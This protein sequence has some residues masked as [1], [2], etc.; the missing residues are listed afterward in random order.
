MK[1]AF[2]GF[3]QSGK[4]TLFN[5]IAGFAGSAA[6]AQR[7]R[8]AVIRIPDPRLDVL[9]HLYQA[10]KL[11]PSTATFIDIEGIVPGRKGNAS[12]LSRIRET[13]CLLGV[14]R[15]EDPVQTLKNLRIELAFA[16][17]EIIEKSMERLERAGRNHSPEQADHQANLALLERLKPFFEE[18]G[19]G[20]PPGLADEEEKRLRGYQFLA[21]KPFLAL[22]NV[23][24]GKEAP[25]C[26]EKT[27]DLHLHVKLEAELME[28]DEDVRIAFM[29]DLGL[30][31]S[32][33]EN[34]LRKSH[35]KLHLTTFF[36]AAPNE[37]RAWEI[38]PGASTVDAAGRIHTDLARGF[39]R[40][41]VF[42]YDDLVR[43]GSERGVKA[44]GKF[45]IEGKDYIVKD[46]DILTIRFNV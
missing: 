44:A 36:T 46:G 18:G 4:S 21:L 2:V 37:V 42:S 8:V 23:E 19:E 1:I 17:L 13:D 30:E 33:L 40:A 29:G 6:A 38:P 25:P 10:E 20:E 32:A 26:L 3:S 45:R 22:Y 43:E 16:D 12:V 31:K 9:H 24:D 14:L 34:V 27:L 11:T 28:L 7:E 35:E 5:A 41:E 15:G 39:I